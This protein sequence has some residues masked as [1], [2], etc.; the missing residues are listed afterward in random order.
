M[1]NDRWF[2]NCYTLTFLDMERHGRPSPASASRLGSSIWPTRWPGVAPRVR[3][4]SQWSA[5]RRRRHWPP[6]GDGKSVRLKFSVLCDADYTASRQNGFQGGA[7]AT[8]DGVPTTLGSFVLSGNKLTLSRVDPAMGR[9][10][11]SG[12]SSGKAVGFDPGG[13]SHIQTNRRAA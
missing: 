11:V 10:G 7:A 5:T 2:G 4:I 9:T 3:S 13:L 1:P 12:S 6:V 8:H